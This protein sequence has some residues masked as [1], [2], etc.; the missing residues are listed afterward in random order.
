MY[1]PIADYAVIGDCRSAALISRDGSIDWCCWPRFDSPALFAR[2]LDWNQGGHFSIRPAIPY[3]S[4]RRYADHSNVLM[5]TFETGS[6]VV[7]ITDLMP[8]MENKE[9]RKHLLPF[10]EILRRVA[11]MRGEVPMRLEFRPRPNY[12][13]D[14][15]RLTLRKRNE[16]AC[17]TRRE[18]ILLGGDAPLAIENGTATSEFTVRSGEKQFFSLTYSNES[19]AVRPL[20]GE[21]AEEKIALSLDYWR[22]WAET[23]RYQGPHRDAVERSAFALKLMLYAPSGAMIAAPT[24]SLPE[25]IGGERN[26]DYRYCWLRDASFTARALYQLGFEEEGDSYCGWLMHA[27]SLSHPGLRI[28]YDVYGRTRLA[29]ET[30]DHMEGYGGSAP[31]RIGNGAYRQAQLD[32]YGEVLIALERHFKGRESLDRDSRKLVHQIAELVSKRWTEPDHGIWEMRTGMFHHVHGKVMA[33]AA[34]DSV[35]RLSDRGLL[36]D[37]RA[38][39]AQAREEI[40][41]AILKRGFHSRHG[42]FV[43]TLD[44]DRLDASLLTIPMTGFLPAGDERMLATTRAIQKRLA[45]GDLVYRYRDVDDGLPGEEGAFVACS[46]W[47]VHNLALAGQRSE[48]L[49]LFD[50]MVRRANDV[51]LYSEEID[52]ESG[53]FLG[54]FPQALTHIALINA[55]LALQDNL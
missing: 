43:S 53:E 26:W 39:W 33:W 16:A 54:N 42:T 11:G 35:L 31:V 28:L 8:V 21:P 3:R 12:G 29:E 17:R 30:L 44:G 46:F 41:Q 4:T 9:K 40:R 50:R 49:T 23:L 32:V 5:T 14:N 48:A 13:R 55:A 22:S 52:P 51:G 24:A 37:G 27:T 18:L 19:P 6:G 34:L 10:R 2:I 25:Q 38:R 20:T 15:S 36:G 45:R 47:L 7:E 1:P